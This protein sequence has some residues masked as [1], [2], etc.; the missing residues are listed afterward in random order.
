MSIFRNKLYLAVVLGHFTVDVFSSMGP[1]LVTFLSISLA[2]STT[3]I[4]LAIGTYHLISAG[5]Q[6]V[7]GWLTDKAGS[8]W[9][10]PGSMIWTASFLA[11]SIFL[12]QTT[13]NFFLFVILFSLAAIGVGAFHPLGTMH[14]GTAT[15]GRA[16]TATAVFFLFGQSGL[17]TGPVLAGLI[18]DNIGTIGI[19][20][21]PFLTLPLLFFMVHAMRH[22]FAH[23]ASTAHGPGEEGITPKEAVRWGAISLLALLVG[24]RSWAFF[25]TISFLPKMFQDMG[26]E[27]TAYGSITGTFCMAS[28]IQNVPVIE[29]LWGIR[30]TKPSRSNHCK[31]SRIGVSLIL[32]W[33]ARSR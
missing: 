3:Q 19:Y 5:S 31:A 13:H 12:A 15:V 9:L 32:S 26:W 27:A 28:A 17:A 30:V 23:S 11:L 8:R 16:A 6:P 4:G 20:V 1:I 7:F 25:G 29:P 18:L 24:L 2:L 22:T 10:G 14:A 33:P 21:L